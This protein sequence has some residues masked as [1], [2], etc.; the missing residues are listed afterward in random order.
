MGPP[1][2]MRPVVDR[3]IVMRH[4]PVCELNYPSCYCSCEC[5]LVCLKVLFLEALVLVCVA[6][7]GFQREHAFLSGYFSVVSF[8]WL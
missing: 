4:I 7:S 2:Y 8:A 5:N 3:N 6:Y 1:S